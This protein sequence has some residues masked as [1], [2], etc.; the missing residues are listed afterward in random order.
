MYVQD[1]GYTIIPGLGILGSTP[2]LISLLSDS[3]ARKFPTLRPDTWYSLAQLYDVQ[4]YKTDQ[5]VFGIRLK[6]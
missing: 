2:Q 1:V 4:K 6:I 5:L 3:K